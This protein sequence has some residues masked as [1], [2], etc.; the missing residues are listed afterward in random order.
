[1]V[2]EISGQSLPIILSYYLE[3]CWGFSQSLQAF[4]PS[5]T[6]RLLGGF[7]RDSTRQLSWSEKEL[8]ACGIILPPGIGVDSLVPSTPKKEVKF[9]NVSVR[10]W[11]NKLSRLHVVFCALGQH[12]NSR[13]RPAAW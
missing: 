11:S 7:G 1:M 13:I 10:T 6:S 4:F 9:D 2:S 5:E 8:P 12:E 3:S